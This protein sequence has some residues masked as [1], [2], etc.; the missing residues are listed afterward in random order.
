MDYVFLICGPLLGLAFGL[1]VH[2][3]LRVRRAI[4]EARHD[5]P[6]DDPDVQ[7]MLR[8][9]IRTGRPMRMVRGQPPEFVDEDRTPRAITTGKGK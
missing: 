9:V 5:D 6:I 4:R 7:S 2:H 1:L 3:E 8:E